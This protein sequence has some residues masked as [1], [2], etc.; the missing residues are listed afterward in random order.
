MKTIQ[1]TADMSTVKCYCY[2][3]G[4]LKLHVPGILNNKDCTVVQW[5]IQLEVTISLKIQY[6]ES[7]IAPGHHTL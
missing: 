1:Q 4:H 2:I 5:I 7:A 3:P 6:V